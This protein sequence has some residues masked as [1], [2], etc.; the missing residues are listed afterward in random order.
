MKGV[1]KN[2]SAAAREAETTKQVTWFLNEQIA[3]VEAA[4]EKAAAT[5]IRHKEGNM[6][7]KKDGRAKSKGAAS[8]TSRSIA[9]RAKLIN[10]VERIRTLYPAFA[11]DAVALV[12]DSNNAARSS[13]QWSS[14]T[15]KVRYKQATLAAAGWS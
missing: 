14:T 5:A 3:A 2:L 9:F 6:T 12:A 4:A 13:L 8:R 15:K 7:K 11:G 10:K 1:E